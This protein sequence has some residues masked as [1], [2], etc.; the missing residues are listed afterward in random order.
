MSRKRKTKEEKKAYAAAYWT[1]YR[2]THKEE[3]AKQ[4]AIFRD[5]HKEEI[6][7]SKLAYYTANK[8]KMDRYEVEYRK[9]HKKELKRKAGIYRKEHKKEINQKH[10]L[11]AK[12]IRGKQLRAKINHKRQRQLGFI[13]INAPFPGSEGHHLNTELVVYIP[14]RLHRSVSHSALKDRNMDKINALA[15]LYWEI[16]EAMNQSLTGISIKGLGEVE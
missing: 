7:K 10:A 13:P 1:D 3:I 12:T 2:E 8:I 9:L 11:F 14:K 15:L 16:E 6:A 5:T 4:Q